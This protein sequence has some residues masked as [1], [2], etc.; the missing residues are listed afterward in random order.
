MPGPLDLSIAVRPPLVVPAGDIDL[1]L[2]L[3][4]HMQMDIL[5]GY[6]GY[7]QNESGSVM[8]DEPSEKITW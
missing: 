4:V 8:V 6:A 5:G 3:G 2:P 1:D 7:S